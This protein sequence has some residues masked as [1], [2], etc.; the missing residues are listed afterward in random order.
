MKAFYDRLNS[1]ADI[2]FD[3]MQ[4][5]TDNIKLHAVSFGVRMSAAANL[6]ECQLNCLGFAVYLMRAY[7]SSSP[8]GFV[9]LDD[10][11]QSMDDGHTE[12]FIA[13]IIPDLL[14]HHGK[15]VIV[16]SH[17]QEI[18]GRLRALNQNRQ[19][20]VYHFEAYQRS[21]PIIT[22]QVRLRML[23]SDIKGA[24]RGNEANRAYAVDR[25]RVLAEHLIR[26]AH[27][28]V[29]GQPAP[30]KYDRATANELLPLFRTIQGT[31]PQEYARL[32]DSVEFSDPSH[33]SEVG[34]TIPQRTNIEPHINRLE[35]LLNKYQL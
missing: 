20:R 16:L 15:Q 2:G 12:A 24:M 8:F 1:G 14:D 35:T 4:P 13:E 22:E 27:L 21:G 7:T 25:I 26:E 23:V 17:A 30:A 3:S 18:T 11:V 6:S 10:P 28:K 31:T 29:M 5:G 19:P 34:Y 32:K 9:L 33:H